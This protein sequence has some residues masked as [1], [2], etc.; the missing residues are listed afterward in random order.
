[1]GDAQRRATNRRYDAKRRQTQPWRKLYADTRWTQG[2]LAYLAEHPLCVR[3]A[4][5]GRVGAA[6][7]VDH[8][9]PHRGDPSLFYDRANWAGLCAMHHDRDKQREEARGYTDMLDADGWPADTRHPANAHPGASVA[10]R[11]PVPT[12]PPPLDS[13]QLLGSEPATPNRA[14]NREMKA[15]G[16]THD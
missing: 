2:R 10:R 9:V 11:G 4:A 6:T 7:V 8:I 1:M 5:L 13:L 12:T 3:C 14:Q 15:G 16:R